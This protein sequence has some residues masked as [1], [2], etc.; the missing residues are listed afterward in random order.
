MGGLSP[1][2]GRGKQG[3]V[4]S[5][6]P[7]LGRFQKLI[8]VFFGPGRPAVPPPR[9]P[10]APQLAQEPDGRKPQE[11]APDAPRLAEAPDVRKQP[12]AAPAAEPLLVERLGVT[13]VSQRRRVVG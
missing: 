7:R 6:A 3:V 8:E 5:I 13:G 4:R 10:D 2:A 11:A 1:Q 12:E 9:W